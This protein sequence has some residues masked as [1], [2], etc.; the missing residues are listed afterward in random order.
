MSTVVS[1]VAGARRLG[2]SG[3][4]LKDVAPRAEAELDR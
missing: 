3:V 1:L 4:A 2:T